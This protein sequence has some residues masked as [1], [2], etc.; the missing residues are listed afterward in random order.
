MKK[1][2]SQDLL[3]AEFKIYLES[4]KNG[5]GESYSKLYIK[6]KVSRLRRI[7]SFISVNKLSNVNQKN[8]LDLLDIVTKELSTPLKT[9]NGTTQNLYKDYYSV[10]RILY[11]MHTK[12]VPPKFTHYGGVRIKK[13][14]NEIIK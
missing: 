14:A 11:V 6:D 9:L 5:S 8:Y 1:I 12:K 4:I 2:E 13:Y 3:I 10:I 7:L